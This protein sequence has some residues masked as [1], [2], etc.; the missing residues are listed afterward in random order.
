MAGS[1][2]RSLVVPFRAIL[3]TA[4]SLQAK[5]TELA[6]EAVSRGIDIETADRLN[7]TAEAAAKQ[8]DCNC[9]VFSFF[10]FRFLLQ[11]DFFFHTHR[12]KAKKSILNG[13]SS[14]MIRSIMRTRSE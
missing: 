6:K 5:Q 12:A 10:F 14:M 2:V 13:I 8:V 7:V 3:L 4:L 11:F 1:F 9:R